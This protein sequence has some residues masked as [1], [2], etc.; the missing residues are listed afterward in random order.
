[1]VVAR[2]RATIKNHLTNFETCKAARGKR[3]S[4]PSGRSGRWSTQ[5]GWDGR[6]KAVSKADFEAL[7]AKGKEKWSETTGHR[8]FIRGYIDQS[9]PKKVVIS[10]AGPDV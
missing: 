10:A 9:D 5:W 2:A 6:S 7:E 3:K 4:G 1:M 8:I